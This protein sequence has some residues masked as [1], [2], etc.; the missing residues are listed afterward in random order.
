MTA[1]AAIPPPDPA[2]LAR[3]REL[4][5][6]LHA[7][8]ADVERWMDEATADNADRLN[9]AQLYGHRV[10]EQLQGARTDLGTLTLVMAERGAGG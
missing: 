4:D 10:L 7:V 6:R 9:R 8:S 3:G 1:P 2:Q 5:D